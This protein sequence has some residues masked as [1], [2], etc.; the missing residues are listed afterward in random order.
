MGRWWRGRWELLPALAEKPSTFL[1]S[2][3]AQVYDIGRRFS[4]SWGHAVV[5]GMLTDAV[6][7][8]P[9]STRHHL[10]LLVPHGV[11]GFHNKTR[12][13]WRRHAQLL[14]SD[15]PLRSRM[16]R[17]ASEYVREELCIAK[18]HR[19]VWQAVLGE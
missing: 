2:L 12:R 9:G 19:A 1:R 8:I 18:K 10:H 16:S 17:A 7:L 14:Q 5:E 6:P 4:E 11:A 3:D 15:V 13:D